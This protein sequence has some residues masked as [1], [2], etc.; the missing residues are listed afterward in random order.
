MWHATEKDE[1]RSVAAIRF[2]RVLENA[3][4]DSFEEDIRTRHEVRD[5]LEYFTR[6]Y[7]CQGIR[8]Y[9]Q[10]FDT[11]DS[12]MMIQSIKRIWSQT[13]LERFIR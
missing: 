12:L 4:R 6:Y 7:P 13:G 5:A 10:G 9:Q 3:A 1:D 2:L 8:I 11:G